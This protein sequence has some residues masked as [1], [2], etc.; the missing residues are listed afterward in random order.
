MNTMKKTKKRT[1]R[2]GVVGL[3]VGKR[4][5]IEG[6][7]T[8][9]DAEVVAIADTNPERIRD[10]GEAYG[11]PGRYL[12]LSDMLRHEKLDVVSIATPN[13]FHK[14]LTLEALRAGCHV[15][16]EKPMALS[17]ED[18]LDM[19]SVSREVK[20]RVMINF[21]SRTSEEACAMKKAVDD[22]LLGD[23]Y[24]ARSIWLRRRRIPGFGGWFGQKALAGGGP[25]IDIGVHRL[26]LALWLMGFPKPV[27]VLGSTCDAIAKPMAERENKAFDVEDFA[28]A[29]IKFEN[30]ATLELEA[31]WCAN[32]KEREH[33]ST[34]LLGTRAGLLHH[35][36]GDVYDSFAE[37][38]LEKDG[39]QY[40][41]K[42]H[43]P[44]PE[45]KTSMYHFVDAILNDRPHMAGPEEGL[46]VMRILDAVYESAGTG[47]P[48]RVR[49]IS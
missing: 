2:C 25:L 6:Y 27:W 20:R 26:D 43:P 31:S 18:A 33:V 37:L 10:V 36:I 8:H 21:S 41:M 49:D 28:V 7:R 16:C 35:N 34:R 40:D 24:F 11:I 17:A 5:H 4:R 14:P 29:L 47:K 46:M 45:A 22:G 13:H 32:I 48:V 3:G 9:P 23:I 1:L 15:L 44:L 30:G 39:C 12:S 42:L 19:I 38:Y